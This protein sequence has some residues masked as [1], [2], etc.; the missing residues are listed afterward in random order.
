MLQHSLDSGLESRAPVISQM[1][2]VYTDDESGSLDDEP[3]G[4]PAS[5]RRQENTGIETHARD[6]NRN[7]VGFR[8]ATS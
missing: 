4:K 3:L 1:I 5:R 6:Q 2:V 8:D 7:E